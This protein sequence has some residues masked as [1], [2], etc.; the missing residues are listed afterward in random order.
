MSRGRTAAVIVHWRHPEE[1]LGCLAALESV[2]DLLPI[3]VD[4]GGTPPIAEHVQ[5]QMPAARVVRSARNLGYAGGANL[6]M[7]MA[8]E[9]AVETVVLLNDDVRLSPAALAAATTVL[10]SD[11]R[12]AVVGP[13]VLLR[14]DP[15]RLWLAWGDVTYGQSLVALH[16]AGAP[17]GPAWSAQRDVDWIGGC[18]MWMRA[19][20][21]R[22]VG[23]F[24]DEF[25][26]YHEEV[27]WCTRARHAGW[28]VV[29][30]PTVVVAHGGR[31]SS[32][33]PASV[34][35]RKYF[36]ARNSIL[37]ARK[38]GTL[39]ERAKLALALAM[40]LP[41]QAAWHLPRGRASDVWL[42]MRG[43]RDG[44]FGRRPP[45]AALGLE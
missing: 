44:L 20:A 26:A 19:A 23:L 45:F 17:D 14:D 41:L 42:K 11:P 4:N 2:S 40:G 37:F 1:T 9:A 18:A 39:A 25:F 21:L 7:R 8:L 30:A 3:V 28:R 33:N 10:A 34:R 16:G 15:Q 12:I 13:K 32:A 35:V 5:A 24:D 31:G 36:A 38:H 27:D 22:A 6:G 29:Y 43:V